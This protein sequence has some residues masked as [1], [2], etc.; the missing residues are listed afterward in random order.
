MS[1]KALM[2]K[3]RGKMLTAA[4]AL[5]LWALSAQA[6]EPLSLSDLLNLGLEKSRLIR[7]SKQELKIAELTREKALAV[8]IPGVS[9]NTTH[10][11]YD[12]SSDV[13]PDWESGWGVSVSQSLHPERKRTHRP[14]HGRRHHF[15]KRP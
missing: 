2:K 4:A 13:F 9:A 11:R 15:P 7:I 12:E 6:A 1:L 14:P 3:Q 10:T 8:M 5:F